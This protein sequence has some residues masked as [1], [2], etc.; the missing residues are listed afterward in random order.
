MLTYFAATEESA[1]GIAAL[2]ING[3]AFL[4]QLVTFVLVFLVLRR[5]A[6]APIV[7]MLQERREVIESGVKLGEEM[8][9]QKAAFDKSV[10]KEMADARAKADDIIASAQ[11]AAK[12]T[13]HD[14]ES[15]AQAKAKVIVDE[16]K[17]RGEQEVV[18]ARKALEAELVDLIS[19]ATETIIGEKVDAK[20]DAALIDRA[21]KESRA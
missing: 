14:A 16:G 19:D 11:T 15:E 4:I 9:V 13:V 7:R 6:F 8:K 20:K 21:L 3:T 12:E 10:A 2:G 17:A 1:E 18:R 5:F